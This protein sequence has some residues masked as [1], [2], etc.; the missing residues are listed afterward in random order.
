ML[1]TLAGETFEFDHVIMATHANITLEILER[2]KGGATDTERQV[3]QGFGWAK[4][5]LVVH[6]DISVSIW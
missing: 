5:D 4:N 2:G 6:S 3:L 1:R